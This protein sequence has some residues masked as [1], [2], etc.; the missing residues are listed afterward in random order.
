MSDA[1]RTSEAE[2]RSGV[3]LVATV[4]NEA[5]TIPRFADSIRR[6]TRRPDEVIIVDGGSTDGTP[7]VLRRELAEV[8][9][10]CVIVESGLNI[11][12][13]RNR[14]ICEARGP[15]IAAS[16]AG[17]VL[18]P[19]W[20]EK[21]VA[22]LEADA[23]VSVASGFYV[24]E[25]HSLLQRCV[26]LAT[27]P[28]QLEPVDPEKFLPSSR[29]VAFRKSA[30]EAAGGYPE[31][32]YTA[33]DTLFDLKLKALGFRFRFVGEAIVEWEPRRTWRSIARQFYLY[34]RGNAHLGRSRH[35][36]QWLAKRVAAV[37]AFGVGGVFWWPIW[38]LLPLLLAYDHIGTVHPLARRVQAVCD[39][40]RAYVVTSLVLWMI[41]WAQWA[42]CV[43]GTIERHWN[44]RRYVDQLDAYMADANGRASG[45]ASQGGAL[46]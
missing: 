26:G 4:F 10:L 27:M 44:R 9:S 16:D 36:L 5:G 30:W 28:G 11:S 39:G 35:Q 38:L 29:S 18:R 14:A 31:W 21:I 7:D 46:P 24:L 13:G 33:E 23:E 19:D 17:C 20:L 2:G 6:Q 43:R 1:E 3:T 25:C 32:L 8:V 12:Q 34:A 42:G 22:P 40:A 15:I 41:T 45:P 37:V